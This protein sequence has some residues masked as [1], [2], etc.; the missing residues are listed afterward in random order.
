MSHKEIIE[1][2]VNLEDSKF[3]NSKRN[4]MMPSAHSM[5]QGHVHR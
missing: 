4:T 5:K 3:L 1:R 2:T